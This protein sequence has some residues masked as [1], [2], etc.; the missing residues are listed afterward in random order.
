MGKKIL[1]VAAV[2]LVGVIY[3]YLYGDSFKQPDIQIQVSMRPKIGPR[4][5]GPKGANVKPGE[6]MTIFILN[7][8]YKLTSVEVIPLSD[9]ATNK[10]PHPVWREI[11]TSN[12]IPTST[13]MYGTKIRG[14]HPEVKDAIA[15]PLLPDTGYRIVIKSVSSKGQHDFK[16]PPEEAPQQ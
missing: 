5:R 1:I 13:F 14:M 15:D 10:Y 3:Y 6:D 12:S 7:R 11:S 4:M 9:I 16:T 8:E 2:L